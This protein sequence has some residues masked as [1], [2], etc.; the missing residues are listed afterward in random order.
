MHT[1]MMQT[2][3]E[4][5]MKTQPRRHYVTT[6]VEMLKDLPAYVEIFVP[7]GLLIVVGVVSLVLVFYL[8]GGVFFL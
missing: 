1:G 3:E 6:A 2:R 7:G 4:H 8:L 5:D